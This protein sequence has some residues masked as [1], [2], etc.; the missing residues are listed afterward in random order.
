MAGYV[1]QGHGEFPLS[2]LHAFDPE[3]DVGDHDPNQDLLGTHLAGNDLVAQ[4]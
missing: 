3:D 4:R 1:R 2:P